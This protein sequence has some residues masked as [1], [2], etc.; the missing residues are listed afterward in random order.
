VTQTFAILLD[1]YRELNAKKLFWIVLALSGLVVAVFALMG[2][3]DRGITF[4]HWTIDFEFA[5]TKFIPRDQFYK[6]IFVN[7]GLAV[8][9]TWIATALALVSTASIFP[10]F[11]AGGAIE[12]ALSKPIG[13]LRLFLTKYAAGLLFVLLQVGLFTGASFLVIGL[14]GGSWEPRILLAIPIVVL[15]FSYLYSVLVLVGV[16]WRST[17][18]ALLVTLLV[19]F[20]IFLINTA[21]T[22]LLA[23]RTQTQV[24]VEAQGRQVDELRAKVKEL[25]T[26]AAAPAGSAKEDSAAPAPERPTEG[27][28]LAGLKYGLEQAADAAQKQ[29]DPATEIKEAQRKLDSRQKRLE[30]VSRT[31]DSLVKW[32]NIAVGIKTML[33]KT[34]ETTALMER[35]V[36]DKSG[37]RQLRA[38]GGGGGPGDQPVRVEVDDPDAPPMPDGR[39]MAE[40]M[41]KQLESRTEWWIIGTS[42]G[43]ECVMIALGAWIFCRR[44]F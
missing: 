33:P 17:I 36:V 43:F 29:A 16:M 26:K 44:E 1:A 14:R 9:L 40:R 34:T 23:I 24:R 31:R 41:E 4:L 10:D 8:W 39:V 42:L 27:G 2:N 37:L 22:T 30:E 5:S 38:E 28:L 35:Y 12:L 19:W 6:I 13:R 20:L 18:A 15:V 7:F 3:N 25:D 32:H 21:D 11:L